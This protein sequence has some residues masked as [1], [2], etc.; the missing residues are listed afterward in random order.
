MPTDG[1]CDDIITL[2]NGEHFNPIPLELALVKHPK[3][4]GAM[5]VGEGKP[6]PAVLLE[7][8]EPGYG[9]DRL[10][11]EVWPVLEAANATVQAYARVSRSKVAVLPPGGL[12]RAPK[13]TV[14]RKLTDEKWNAVIGQLYNENAGRA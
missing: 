1:S 12:V 7:L 6:Q 3:I 11:Y 10:I 8:S 14:V 4:A 2:P 5:V 9:L 13:G